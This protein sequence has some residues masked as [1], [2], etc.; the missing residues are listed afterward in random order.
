MCRL[1]CTFANLSI[2]YNNVGS[3]PFWWAK[4]ACF[5]FSSSKIY[6]RCTGGIA[7]STGVKMGVHLLAFLWP[8]LFV[9][10]VMVPAIILLLDFCDLLCVKM[11]WPSFSFIDFILWLWV[12]GAGYLT[13]VIFILMNFISRLKQSFLKG[14]FIAHIS[15][16][17]FFFFK[18]TR[19]HIK[20]YKIAKI[21]QIF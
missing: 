13:P 9:S 12:L 7:L 5:D 15:Q 17:V 16:E 4:L 19:F 14:L 18:I 10:S 20:F 21:I 3:K 2:L 1:C 8:A 11:C 6:W